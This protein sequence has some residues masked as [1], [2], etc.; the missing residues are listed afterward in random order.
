M[1]AWLWAQTGDTKY[2]EQAD[3]LFAGGVARAS[4]NNP[5]QFNQN[6]F[7][8]FDYVGWRSLPRKGSGRSQLNEHR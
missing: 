2:S 3:A 1:Y 7:W 8:S 5:R 4:L 6:F